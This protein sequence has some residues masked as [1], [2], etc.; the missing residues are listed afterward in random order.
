VATDA[1]AE[2]AQDE[3]VTEAP[4]A[5][6]EAKVEGDESEPD[7]DPQPDETPEQAQQRQH[8]NRSRN[9]R[10]INAAQRRVGR[11][12][13]ERDLMARQNKELAE[14]LAALEAGK[15]LA[16]KADP[17]AAPDQ[18]AAPADASSA[19]DLLVEP[20]EEDFEKYSDYVKALTKHEL[21]VKDAAV[22]A[23]R[24][25]D[26]ERTR[27]QEAA[28]AFQTRQEAAR[29]KH[30]DFD[31]VVNQPIPVNQAIVHAI[32]TREAG[33]DLAYFL[34][35]N[36]AECQRIA[37]LSNADA[38][39]EIGK[40]EARLVTATAPAPAARQTTSAPAPL[41]PVG[42]HATRSTVPAGQLSYSEYKAK[43]LA[44]GRR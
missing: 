10:R 24:I 21:A 13:A 36:P 33:P 3:P 25:A 12:E 14:R 34:G 18:A 20:K 17:T 26:E 35:K 41:Q 37:A 31:D 16:P 7:E 40:L 39:V 22:T 11:A 29:A 4:I 23:A 32:R 27:S 42:G 2:P 6:V 30:A 15:P 19:A 8:R 5:P 9:Q 44:Q 38:M 28:R 43:R 1:V